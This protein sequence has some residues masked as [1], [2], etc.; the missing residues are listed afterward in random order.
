MADITSGKE[1]SR[2]VKIVDINPN[3]EIIDYIT[4]YDHIDLHYD[5]LMGANIGICKYCGSLFRQNKLLN[6]K[7]CY[8]HRG[9]NKKEPSVIKCTNCGVEFSIVGRTKRTLCNVCYKRKRYLV[10]NG[11]ALQ[12]TKI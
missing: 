3:S 5:R 11:K 9:Y 8:K 2:F 6:A 10:K 12:N 1:K 7:Y 4:D